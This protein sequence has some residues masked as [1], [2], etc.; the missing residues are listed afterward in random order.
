MI[1][2]V[3]VAVVVVVVQAFLNGGQCLMLLVTCTQQASQEV[4]GLG[5]WFVSHLQKIW[6][7]ETF[8]S[9]TILL[10]IRSLAGSFLY[11]TISGCHQSAYHNEP[12]PKT[13]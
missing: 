4:L 3:A 5:S 13:G 10:M 2:A 1:H 9:G 6:N 11:R 7:K 8:F 12:R